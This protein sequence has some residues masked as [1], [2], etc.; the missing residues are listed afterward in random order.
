MIA[1]VGSIVWWCCVLSS[2]C[3]YAQ[4]EKIVLR[5][6]NVHDEAQVTV[7]VP[8]TLEVAITGVNG[9]VSTPDLQH[10]D[11]E[12][13]HKVGVRMVTVN[14]TTST[15]YLFRGY[16]DETGIHKVGPAVINIGQKSICSNVLDIDVG[17][18]RA[19]SS[20]MVMSAG[21]KLHHISRQ[22]HKSSGELVL[23]IDHN[24][25]VVG[26][27]IGCTLT[28][29]CPQGSAS[30]INIGSDVASMRGQNIEGPDIRVIQKDGVAY[31]QAVW[32]WS[33]YPDK[34][35]SLVIPSYYADILVQEKKRGM[36]F[37]DLFVAQAAQKRIYSNAQTVC[38]QERPASFEDV[39]VI[40][41]FDSYEAQL[42]PD[43]IKEGEAGRLIFRL[44]GVGNME[45]MSPNLQNID[46]HLKIYPSTT[47]TEQLADGRMCKSFEYVVQ[48]T[49]SGTWEIP[50]QTCIVG[51]TRTMSRV[52]LKTKPLYLTVLP[53]V[54]RT[55][56]VTTTKHYDAPE[57]P[58]QVDGLIDI[59]IAD[60]HSRLLPMLPWIWFLLLCTIPF[61]GLGLYQLCCVY[62]WFDPR[63]FIRQLARKAHK[64]IHRAQKDRD[65]RMLYSIIMQ[66]IADGLARPS[67][68]ISV[69]LIDRL[70]KEH[71]SEH[72][73]IVWHTFFD[74]ISE[75]HFGQN[76][77]YDEMIFVQ[78]H[79]WI[80]RLKGLL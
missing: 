33:L 4:Q 70:Q 49:K 9:H 50:I 57:S 77:P 45:D 32:R 7:G 23:D 12:K 21:N 65:P 27:R 79:Q 63:F 62:L 28:F 75:Y 31:E 26:Q 20:S 34:A 6:S 35:G 68:S 64:K 41:M 80:D 11:K 10:V 5:F 71:L 25:V 1:V 67:A 55:L 60:K 46:D 44:C 36:G 61:V 30:L 16:F 69:E 24:N 52:E 37:F 18:G 48:A 56:A 59:R 17:V 8:V 40:G 66:F 53:I 3:M 76:V 15:T 14:G 13:W 73:R 51:D 42:R 29:S 2:F 39:D 43:R 78:A 72:D 22:S 74:R 38:V 47:K 19:S 58:T 54:Q